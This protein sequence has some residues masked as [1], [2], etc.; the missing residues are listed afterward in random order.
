MRI[1]G[2]H[3]CGKERREAFK[4]LRNLHAVLCPRGYAERVVSSFAHQMQL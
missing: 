4:L 3:H 1:L 2:T